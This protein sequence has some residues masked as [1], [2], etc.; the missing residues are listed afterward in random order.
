MLC[1]CE[2]I[3]KISESQLH[4]RY[5]KIR[6]GRWRPYR[7]SVEISQSLSRRLIFCRVFDRGRERERGRE[8][9]ER[10]HISWNNVIHTS[11]FE[12]R[13]HFHNKLNMWYQT[14][15]LHD[16]NYVHD[17]RKS[18]IISN[19]CQQTGLLLI[20]GRSA[21]YKILVCYCAIEIRAS[22]ELRQIHSFN[23]LHQTV[24]IYLDLPNVYFFCT[25]L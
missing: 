14:W 9:E 25:F 4:T 1:M 3:L 5:F 2:F 21:D 10:A 16:S 20:H 7:T 17:S 24:S 23:L 13:I 6:S 19:R 11:A 15:R 18:K 22:L 8:E 12:T